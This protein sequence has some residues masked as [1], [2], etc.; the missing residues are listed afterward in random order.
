M[1]HQSR[2]KPN[3]FVVSETQRSEVGFHY[4]LACIW[5]PLGFQVCLGPDIYPLTAVQ[6]NLREHENPKLTPMVRLE[7]APTGPGEN[8]GLPNY[9]LNLHVT[10]PDRKKGVKSDNFLKL[11]DPA[12]TIHPLD[13]FPEL[14]YNV[15]YQ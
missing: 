13:I 5:Q 1:P 3:A 2:V 7:T 8:I 11:K 9:F 12:L 14:R 4:V 15:N 10:A 6:P